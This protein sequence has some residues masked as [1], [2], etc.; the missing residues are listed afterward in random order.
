MWKSLLPAGCS[1]LRPS[2]RAE[3]VHC[4]LRL[5][6]TAEM[7]SAIGKWISTTCCACF[8]SSAVL[9]SKGFIMLATCLRSFNALK[10]L[11]LHNCAFG[12]S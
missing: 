5:N 8:A 4:A 9:R 3:L 1:T 10:F 6:A 2:G 7:N 11:K 12:C